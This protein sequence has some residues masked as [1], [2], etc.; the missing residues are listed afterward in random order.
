MEIIRRE[1]MNFIEEALNNCHNGEDFVAAMTD[2]YNHFEIREILDDYHD[3]IRNIITIIDYDTDLQMEG[4]DFKSYDS[5]IKALKDIGLFEEAEALSLLNENSSDKDIE[6]C[7]QKLALN[8][9]YDEF[10]NRVYL[11]AE[12][13]LKVL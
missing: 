6:R 2:I 11:Y 1:K 7:Y 4:L 10:W 13:N 3:W 8:N 12:R 9:N 5:Q